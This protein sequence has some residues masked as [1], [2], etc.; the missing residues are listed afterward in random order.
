MLHGNALQMLGQLPGEGGVPATP[1]MI[2][3]YRGEMAEVL[4]TGEIREFEFVLDALP[5]DR[6]E[7]YHIRMVAEYGADGKIAG[8]LTTWFDVTE[9][10]RMQDEL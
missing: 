1:E 7:H 5:Q 6:R 9:R 10:K 2:V 3:C 4:A 8:T